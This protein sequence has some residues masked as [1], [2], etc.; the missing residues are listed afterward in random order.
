MRY[1]Q[2]QALGDNLGRAGRA[3]ELAPAS[4]RGA[5]TTTTLCRLR[6]GDFPVCVTGADALDDPRILA[7]L[8]GQRYA[9]R[10]Q[11]ARQIAGTR[12]SHHHGRQT[13][14]TGRHAQH[15][16]GCRQGAD[17]STEYDRSIVAVRQAV[18]HAHRS[19][20]TSVTGIAAVARKGNATAGTNLLSP[21][22]HQQPDFPVT[23]VVAKSHR[24]TVR[25]T[26]ATQGAKNEKFLSA[27]LAR[28]P[29]HPRVLRP[30][31][32]MAAGRLSKCL[33]R[34]R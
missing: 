13:F 23:G 29:A 22:L 30:A 34:Q 11:H 19:L 7:F 1:R 32:K 33:V 9:P 25:S 2:T 12:Q 14:V 21:R 16:A 4:R 31:E 18:H 20:R 8:R 5:S 26:H 10:H 28:L 15:A 6:Q 27:Q 3:Q 17:Q 24:A